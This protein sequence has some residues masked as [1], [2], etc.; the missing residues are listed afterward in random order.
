MHSPASI[1][2]PNTEKQ[3]Q[4]WCRHV[5]TYPSYSYQLM[6]KLSVIV[7]QMAFFLLLFFGINCVRVMLLLLLTHISLI[8]TVLIRVHCNILVPQ[9]DRDLTEMNNIS[10]ILSSL[11]CFSEHYSVAADSCWGRWPKWYSGG[12]RSFNEPWTRVI[13]WM[14]CYRKHFLHLR[15]RWLVLSRG[16]TRVRADSLKSLP[17]STHILWSSVQMSLTQKTIVWQSIM[18]FWQGVKPD[19]SCGNKTRISCGCI[20]GFWKWKAG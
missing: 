2:Q 8:I 3:C 17:K 19:L 11:H 14:S 9:E 20:R 13:Q 4:L 12:D 10:Y 15:S 1:I 5:V 6:Q 7:L 16:F 18:D